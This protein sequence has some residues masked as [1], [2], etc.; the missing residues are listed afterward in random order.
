[1]CAL[2]SRGLIPSFCITSTRCFATAGAGF[3]IVM[4]RSGDSSDA[5]FLIVDSRKG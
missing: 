3:T 2:L 5:T 4:S 1:M